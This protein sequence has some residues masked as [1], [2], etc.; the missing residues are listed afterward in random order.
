[1]ATRLKLV[2]VVCAAL[3][4]LS[5]CT[6]NETQDPTPTEATEQQTTPEEAGPDKNDA[7]LAEID[8]KVGE[9]EQ[10]VTFEDDLDIIA[11]R[12]SSVGR[13][14]VALE[15]NTVRASGEVLTV[16]FTVRNKSDTKWQIGSYAFDSGEMKLPL[17]TQDSELSTD[18]DLELSIP[19]LSTTDGVTV[20]DN[21][22]GQVYR[23]A[24]DS[25][26]N[27]LCSTG[28]SGTFVDPGQAVILS[29]RFAAPPEDLATVTVEIPK[30]GTFDDVPVQR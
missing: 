6:G 11:S 17:S 16:M 20:T 4:T 28:L 21:V 25:S 27:C 18:T 29:T 19:N 10:E 13:H 22:N 9:D 2:T 23:A 14:E 30:F 1:M 3:L 24:Y 5:A 26:G 8:E 12:E 7:A 15:L